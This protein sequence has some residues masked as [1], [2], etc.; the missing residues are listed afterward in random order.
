MSKIQFMFGVHIHQPVGNFG[1]VIEEAYRNCYLP[2]LKKVSRFPFFR[3]ALHISG[4]LLEW[5]EEEEPEFIDLLID[6]V[7]NNRVEILGGGFYEPIL[8]SIPERDAK[9]QIGM[10]SD[11]IE[12]LFGARPQGMWLAERIW[13]PDLPRV[14]AGSG[15]RYTILDDTHFHYAGLPED[16]I[17]GYY[18]T[19]SLGNPLLLFP[20]SKTLRYTIPFKLPE[21]SIAFLKHARDD[22]GLEGVTFADDGEKFGVWPGTGKW[23]FEEGWLEQF[24]R[25]LEESS[26]HIEMVH[27]KEF[28]DSHPPMDRVYIPH[29]SYEEMMEWAMPVESIIRYRDLEREIKDH[30]LDIKCRQFLRGGYWHNF[31][32]KYEEAN[33]LHK[34]ML[35]VS[36]KVNAPEMEFRRQEGDPAW[37]EAARH[38]WKGQ[39][40]C[41]YWHG[42]FGGLYL[43]YLRHA[44]YENLILAETM[45]DELSGRISG[46]HIDPEDFN[47]DGMDEI[48]VET[49]DLKAMVSPHC[50]G[51]LLE[52]DYRPKAFNL[53]N[54]IKNRPEAYHELIRELSKSHNGG[55]SDSEPLSIH[56]IVKAKE[57]GLGTFIRYDRFPRYSFMDHVLPPD[58]T[59][60]KFREN[61]LGELG[62]FT[63]KGY[64]VDLESWKSRL[65]TKR[66]RLIRPGRVKDGDRETPL[67]IRKDYMFERQ[68]CLG[69][70]YRITTSGFGSLDLWFGFE[71]NMT[72]LAGC[73]PDRYFEFG[74]GRRE[75]LD[76]AGEIKKV[77]SL[78]IVDE[79]SR[80]SVSMEYESP[81]L[82]WYG[83]IETVSQ[84]ENGFERLYQ[85]FSLLASWRVILHEDEELYLP[86]HVAL[87]SI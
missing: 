85:G 1:W 24:L 28:I 64:R 16:K 31:M 15:I 68:S 36:R 69:V 21:D 13:E 37:R 79:W 25:A 18:I 66:F 61:N 46:L 53:L 26:E 12:K 47:L 82:I 60:D 74:D 11:H 42:L 76:A 83:P 5:I 55:E 65:H 72:L 39:C 35:M 30:G 50:G 9:E 75:Q 73:A 4:P 77:S 57:E 44:V 52:L 40:N 45:I 8:S 59:F 7:H 62:D 67:T 3:F 22:Y 34:R 10:M 17:G 86:V 87:S 48:V 43:N 32:T 29:A 78:K 23:V 84:S 56:E 58:S 38:L 54:V 27:Y 19:E 2:F 80:M 63:D 6:L 41:A 20:I 81:A 49:P 14:L 71:M 70:V 51:S 33:H